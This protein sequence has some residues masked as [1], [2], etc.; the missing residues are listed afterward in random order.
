MTV[1]Y[2]MK[3]SMATLYSLS[4]TI[5]YLFVTF[6]HSLTR[7]WHTGLDKENKRKWLTAGQGITSFCW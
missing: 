7:C 6:L 3:K 2:S 4:V 5:C 1:Q